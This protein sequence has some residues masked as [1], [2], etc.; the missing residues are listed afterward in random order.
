MSFAEQV[1]LEP[2]E[3]ANELGRE[4][5]HLGEVPG[6]G[7][8]LLAQTVMNGVADLLRKRCFELRRGLGEGLDLVARPFQRRLD[9]GRLRPS[10][11]R[12]SQPLVR[13]FDRD[14]IH[15]LQR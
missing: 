14:R 7:Q 10:L 6:H 1:A 5:P 3:P 8:H 15:G 4:A 11:G 13:P 12:L 2:L 9:G